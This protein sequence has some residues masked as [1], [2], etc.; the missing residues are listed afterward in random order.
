MAALPMLSRRWIINYLLF[1][2]IV[3]F[4][5]IGIR[6][7]I[8]D[9][10]MINR[11]AV[12]TVKP[13][14]VDQ[15]RL[16]TADGSIDLV[17]SETRW[18]LNAPINWFASNIAAERLAGLA[19]FEY[20]SKLPRTE[21]D[22]STLGLTLPKAVLSLNN[23]NISFGD[24]NQI[25]N[26]RY[27]LIRDTVY[28][29]SDVHF[30]LIN[31]GLAGLVD[32]RLLPPGLELTRVQLPTL[33]LVRDQGQWQNQG[34]SYAAEA[35]TQLVSN[36]QRREAAMVQAYDSSITPLNKIMVETNAG[37]I[38]FF[39]LSIQ[40]EI[41]IARPDLKLQYHFPDH[42]YYELLSLDRPDDT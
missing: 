31:Q 22:L 9:E 15:I 33:Q 30:P 25:G 16:E 36:W 35:I 34:K 13:A 28:L 41:I 5:W 19:G 1:V 39:L 7:P 2:L 38:E 23:I 27:L 42:Q 6:Y 8:T 24:S 14:A 11:N 3:I 40:P 32:K 20:Q 21:I 26:R 17:K 12:T 4:T 18:M 10:Q 37:T 29:V